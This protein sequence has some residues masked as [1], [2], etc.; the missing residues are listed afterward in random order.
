MLGGVGSRCSHDELNLGE[1]SQG[2]QRAER[3][4]KQTQN[5]DLLV[6]RKVGGP[7]D[8]QHPLRARN[9]RVQTVPSHLRQHAR[10]SHLRASFLADNGLKIA[11][12]G[13]EGVG[14]DRGADEVVRVDDVG[15]PVPHCLVDGVLQ[16]AAA[17]LDGHHLP[18][19]DKLLLLLLVLFSHHKISRPHTEIYAA[20]RSRVA[21][22]KRAYFH[23]SGF[24]RS[25]QHH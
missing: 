3:G 11:H 22:N 8:T 16:S 7:R 13:G 4:A 1:E 25:N 10:R 2:R 12:D 18:R 5:Y 20:D 6:R 14:A 24:T 15:H 17:G 23:F 19:C 21:T 9:E